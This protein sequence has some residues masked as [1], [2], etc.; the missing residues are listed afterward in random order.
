MAGN[1]V[2]ADKFEPS[3]GKIIGGRY[4]CMVSWDEVPHLSE[5]AKSELLATIPPHQ[6]DARTKGIPQLG[7]G[8]IYPVCEEDVAVNDFALPDHWPRAYALDVGWNATAAIFGAWDRNCD[9]VYVYSAYKR[10][11]AEPPVH[12]AAIRAKG[13][14]IPGVIDPAARGR[15]QSD[16]KQLIQIY[17]QLGLTLTAADNDV[18]AG[19]YTVWQ[20]LITGRLKVFKSCGTWFDEFRLYRRNKDGKIVKEDDH[21]M[22]CTRYL[23]MS[24]LRLACTEPITDYEAQ[25]WAARA[26]R[27][28]NG[29]TG[30]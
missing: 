7:S 4:V 9:V 13:E 16:G 1:T 17:R 25:D 27:G 20:R 10:G 14:W 5:E 28:R 23:M 11:Q 8:A 12:A 19:I 24:G 6:R 18:E 15:A 3:Y 22:D 30:Y 21:L 26:Q 29:T 2:G